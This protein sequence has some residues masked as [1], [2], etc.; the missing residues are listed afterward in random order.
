MRNL[1]PDELKQ[2]NLA[3]VRLRAG[4]LSHCL[5]K[6]L[7]GYQ[8]N[9]GEVI[10]WEALDVLIIGKIGADN[11]RGRFERWASI[12]T[13]ASLQGVRLVLDFT[14]DH[15]GNKTPM[16]PFYEWAVHKVDAFAA[17]SE[18]LLKRV[19]SVRDLPGRVIE[20]AVEFSVRPP[21]RG[22]KY[23]EPTLFWFG[24][25]T[26]INSLADFLNSISSHKKFRLNIMTN[27][28]GLQLLGAFP[29]SW[30]KFV[31]PVATSWSVAGVEKLASECDF[32]IIPATPATVKK[33]A[34][35]NRLITSLTLGLPVFAG[36]IDS[37]RDF[38]DYFS[39][40]GELSTKEIEK[41]TS[42]GYDKVIAAQENICRDYTF[43]N[44]GTTWANFLLA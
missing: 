26:N 14:D 6:E 10:D 23:Q 22:L 1:Y 35:T 31:N 3:S 4:P 11:S 27:D 8:L 19:L 15:L 9:L 41:V 20:D 39:P 12:I 37:Y 13:Q 32:T 28:V 21:Q 16:T 29:I 24:H 33:G 2:Y 7:V 17:S 38:K 44:I 18:H 40:I 43:D 36:D 5:N 34:S 30:N 42:E 25:S